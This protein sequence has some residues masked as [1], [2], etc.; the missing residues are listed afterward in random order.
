M[1]A[2]QGDHGVGLI[3][4]FSVEGGNGGGINHPA[5]GV[6]VGDRVRVCRDVT[7]GT[8]HDASL[9]F[10]HVISGNDHI[11]QIKGDLTGRTIAVMLVRPT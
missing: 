5:L 7:D 6:R 11:Q 9:Y 10:E 4:S 2:I 8:A 1:A 3:L